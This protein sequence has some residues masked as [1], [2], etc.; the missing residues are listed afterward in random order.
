[1]LIIQE[2][3]HYLS[4]ISNSFLNYLFAGKGNS[5]EKICLFAGHNYDKVISTYVVDYIIEMANYAD[6]Y[7]IS[8]I[9]LP[10]S[11]LLKIKSYVKNS[12]FSNNQDNFIEAYSEL[13]ENYV[14]WDII[15]KYEE[16]ILLNDS[17]ICV[18]SFKSIFSKMDS[19]HT[20]VWGLLPSKIKEKQISN[21]QK[22]YL[23]DK[24]PDLYLDACFLAIRS[25]FFNTLEFRNFFCPDML[26]NNQINNDDYG[27]ELGLFF[28]KNK[29]KI[30]CYFKLFYLNSASSVAEA[31]MLIK[32]G[33]PLLKID[34]FVEN[35]ENINE[36]DN[37]SIS[38]EKFCD[39]PYLSYIY[40]IRRERNVVIDS[41][42]LTKYNKIFEIIKYVIPTFINDLFSFKKTNLNEKKHSKSFLK[43][44]IK[45]LTPQALHD[46]VKMPKI[47]LK[48]INNKK[49]RFTFKKRPSKLGY[50]PSHIKN[51]DIIQK[52][53]LC[54]LLNNYN[55]NVV[56]FFN[57]MR[58]SISGGM[59][60][61]DRLAKNASEIMKDVTV[62]QSGLPLNNAIFDNPYFDYAI[63]PISFKYL[64]KE[65]LPNK[66]LLNIPEYFL[67]D[68]I[69]DLTNEELIWLWS[70]SDFRINILNQS[71]ELMPPLY[72][73]EEAKFIC[74]NKLTITAAHQRYCV[75]EKEIEYKCPIYLLTPFIPKLHITPF[76]KKQKIIVLSP[77]INQY[78]NSIVHLLMKE[79][80]DF[81]FVTISKMKVEDYKK[82]ISKAM[83][84]ITFG[85]G[86]DGYFIEPVLCGSISF[87]VYNN[88]YFPKDI[89]KL[90][91]LYSSW[92]DLEKNIV[93]DI[94]K[95]SS[96]PNEYNAISK[97]LRNEINKFT[98]T[99]LAIKNL[100]DLYERFM[101]PLY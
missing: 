89:C 96:D 22:S 39:Y 49:L 100:E 44:L 7:Y 50:Y 16:L 5:V 79:L 18:N 17:C 86:Y 87:A 52:K 82:L 38:C 88:L 47:L 68:F 76:N 58:E 4:L 29:L 66:L 75:R 51:Y 42:K 27:K 94:K 14:G 72:N 20:D 97:L 54:E 28:L 85:E 60:S 10:E 46:V 70:I 11:E 21:E 67:K 91:T 55:G 48:T 98:N 63:P 31:L 71:D 8:D 15:S 41:S 74:S 37:L 43:T 64:I 36:V 84:A 24:D 6:V 3:L 73:I 90:D 32:N 45:A 56:I 19:I 12:W 92:I 95:Y 83:F 61:I 30:Y 1:M 78:K 40:N 35:I 101:S 53:R 25:E 59:L 33:F 62:I 2:I 23:D 80:P 99:D 34:N 65:I 77:D 26:K 13:I 81:K 57:I 9:E 93:N 69:S